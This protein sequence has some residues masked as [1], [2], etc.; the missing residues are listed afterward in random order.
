VSYIDVVG[1]I[2]GE[3]LLQ[4]G[5]DRLAHAVGGGQRVGAGRLVDVDDGGR[6]AVVAAELVAGLGAEF[7]PADVLD[8]HQRAVGTWRA[9]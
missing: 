7:D 5:L 2:L 3:A 8:P 4:L 6:L 9:R 1:D